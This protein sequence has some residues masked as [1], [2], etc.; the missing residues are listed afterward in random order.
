M[1]GPRGSSG[2]PRLPWLA[3]TALRWLLPS[4]E[5]EV[6]LSELRELW[7]QRVTR[8]G[9]DA[10]ARRWYTR[11]ARAYPMRLLRERARRM[12]R[13]GGDARAG[14]GQL[15]ARPSMLTGLRGETKQAARGLARSRMLA[16]TI[17]LTVG[18]GIGATTTMLA[19]VRAVLLDAV[20]Y[21]A[22][23]RLVRIYHAIGENRW[24]LSVV[25]Y[26]AIETQQT[27]F[28][29]VAAQTTAEQT[30]TIGDVV[31]R[32]QVRG[33]TAGWFDLLGIRALHGRTFRESDG[34]PGAP[35][36]A[37][38]SWAFWQW[39]LDGDAG[40]ADRSIRL[41]EREYTVI[42]VLSREADPLTERYGVF[43]ILQFEPPQRKGPFM[44]Q[45]LG[46]VRSDTDEAVAA[47]ELHT[48]N[49]RIF[50]IWQATWADSTSTWGMMPLTEWVT[51]RFRTLLLVLLGAV[52]LVLLI[53]STNA[54]GLLTARAT[55]RR[56]ELAT[57][58]ALGAS[59]PQLLRLLIAES[60][61]LAAGG[62]LLGLTIAGV[63]MR[64]IRAA[65]PSLLPRSSAITLDGMVL[66]FAALLTLCSVVLFGV[67]PALQLLGSSGG[68][69]GTLRSGART[70]TGDART[71]RVRRVMVGS[72]FAIAVPLLVGAA[73]LLNSFVQ[74]QRVDAGFDGEGVLTLRIAR[75][76][77]SAGP[78]DGPFWEQLEERIRALPGVAAAG[79]NSG[80]PP[81]EAGNINNFDPLDRPTPAG[82]TEPL[83]VWL[84]ASPGYFEAM[85]VR[86][87]AG[88][89]FDESDGP[90]NP[91]T[92][93][94]VDRTWARNIYPG[95][96]PI[97]R[98]LYEGG[99]KSPECSIVTIVGVVEDVR[100]LG[101]DDSQQAAA[102]GTVYVPQAQWL[103]SS[104]YLFVRARAE[105]LRLLAPIRAIIRELDPTIALT[106]VAT[107]EQLMTSAL[108][109]P[110]NMAGALIGFA[111]VALVLAMIGIYGVMSYFV[112]EHRKDIGVRLALGGRAT[113]VLGHVLGRGMVPV[114][115]GTAV[116]FGVAF[117]LTRFISRLLFG[118][119][120]NDPATLGMVAL[121]MMST[122]LLACWLPARQ[123]SR[124]DPAQILRAD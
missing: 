74:L 51:A 52:G 122:A 43:P 109:I 102:I 50:P 105:P 75:T 9:D 25:D 46:R 30:L 8:Q 83:A 101:L 15:S 48:I 95:E 81:R 100:Y 33:V 28:D 5:R 12:L 22:A 92:S 18:L 20:P 96:D 93:A 91:N 104:P 65:G 61:L 123:A 71:H 124:L 27:R 37:V 121:A 84:V 107:G 115:L 57:R 106:A 70:L 17:V 73:L 56:I 14:A 38:V 36:T 114:L 16:T 117:A 24:N 85:R 64:A 41:D 58:T 66:G 77:A 42:G 60:L 110:R 99:C 44:L 69:A 67:F 53:A 49:R 29:G 118:V 39:Y 89:M 112:T 21:P 108:A 78:D 87:V 35:A 68:T 45:V 4:A 2:P 86:L 103:A 55:Q 59:R 19:V 26:Q 111:V 13:R 3:R 80:R 47:A 7:E 63:G 62:A 6:V 1:S 11:Q 40:V 94:L 10:A 119:S 76:T 72:Q 54:A 98:R 116:G 34:E 23:D 88:R 31:E 90:D 113:A 120:P 79:V 32:V 82:E 97:G